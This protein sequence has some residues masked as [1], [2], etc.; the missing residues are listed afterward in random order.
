MD[1]D[2]THPQG[3]EKLLTDSEV[4]TALVAGDKSVLLR[5]LT[6][7]QFEAARRPNSTAEYDLQVRM[8]LIYSNASRMVGPREQRAYKD[9]AL[10]VLTNVNAVIT[11]ELSELSRQTAA[12][13]NR[14]GL[15]QRIEAL[16]Q[17]IQRVIELRAELLR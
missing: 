2:L 6:Q 12:A 8:A 13:A 3:T 7:Q 16:R 5:W 17:L 9:Q 10:Q 1:K 14:P 15:Q 4:T 11:G